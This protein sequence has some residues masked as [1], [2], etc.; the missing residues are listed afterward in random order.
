MFEI[1]EFYSDIEFKGFEDNVN[2]AGTDTVCND[3]SWGGERRTW[4]ILLKYISGHND[5]S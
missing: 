2:M 1:N 3:G 5:N 4:T